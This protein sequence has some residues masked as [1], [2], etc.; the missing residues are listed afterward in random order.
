MIAQYTLKKEDQMKIKS[1][2]YRPAIDLNQIE[3]CHI[4][5]KILFRFVREGVPY[6][7][8][9]SGSNPSTGGWSFRQVGLLTN[10]I[11]GSYRCVLVEC[12]E[13]KQNYKARFSSYFKKRS[14]FVCN[15]VNF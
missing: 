3:S 6:Q 10:F 1:S 4:S 14:F 11:L 12:I 15:K 13:K 9:A 7:R 8:E 2:S 5:R